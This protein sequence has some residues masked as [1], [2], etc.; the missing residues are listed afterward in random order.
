MKF[1]VAC[2]LFVLT[3]AG[4]RSSREAKNTDIHP[5]DTAQH[6]PTPKLSPP[7][8]I[9]QNVSQVEAVVE[10]IEFIDEAQFNIGIFIISSTPV[11]GRTSIV[12]PGQRLIV[13]PQYI[14]DPSGVI[15]MTNET[16][17]RLLTMK[18]TQNGQSF[19]GKI[20]MNRQGAWNLVDIDQQK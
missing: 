18:S 11:G 5:P 13:S 16:N 9:G 19:K 15:D 7:A 10:N 2:I 20:T 3:V 14:R 4:C 6:P 1:P 17:K 8:S 12:E